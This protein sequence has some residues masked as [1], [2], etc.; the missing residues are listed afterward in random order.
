MAHGKVDIK[1]YDKLET[2][3]HPLLFFFS[4]FQ[5][6]KERKQA[7]TCFYSLY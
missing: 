3:Q 5:K 2:E 4:F 7:E 1:S 6:K